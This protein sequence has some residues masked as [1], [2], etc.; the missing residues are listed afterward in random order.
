M[1]K[2][3]TRDSVTDKPCACGYL[4][5]AARDPDLPIEFD[6][7]LREYHFRYQIPGD[8]MPSVLVIY[9]C[10]WC[11]GAV[12]PSLRGNLFHEIPTAERDRLL[13]RLESV[14]TLRDAVEQLGEPDDDNPRGSMDCFSEEGTHPPLDVVYR[15]LSYRSLS[16]VAEVR[17]AEH[18]DGTVS[19]VFS[20]KQIR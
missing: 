16:D 14:R 2:G 20:G 15:T 4:E 19:F 18:P 3:P 11:G 9:H 1:K 12:P 10:P 8:E 17:I 5:R 13:A 6:E 7:R